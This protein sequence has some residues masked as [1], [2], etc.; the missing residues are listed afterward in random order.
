[1]KLKL[2]IVCL[3]VC[4]ASG[5][6]VWVRREAIQALTT[7]LV[8]D[9]LG[10][11]VRRSVVRGA[12][13]ADSL[14][15]QWEALSQTFRPNYNKNFPPQ[16]PQRTLSVDFA[17]RVRNCADEAAAKAAGVDVAQVR[18]AI[19][20]VEKSYRGILPEGFAYETYA[21]FRVYNALLP[22]S[23]GAA[24]FERRYGECLYSL[25]DPPPAELQIAVRVLCEQII[26]VGLADGLIFA[27]NVQDDENQDIKQIS[28][29]L[30]RPAELSARLLLEKQSGR[31]GFRI[32]PDLA[33][34]LLR[35]YLCRLKFID[36]SL[37]EYF[38]NPQY[39]VKFNP[40]DY[41]ALQIEIAI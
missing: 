36:F 27:T 3:R 8:S 25:F 9:D 12:Q 29:T 20:G 21:A 6:A 15:A 23:D 41:T 13:L 26:Q 38:L 16:F 2:F 11:T 14:D 32:L 40:D 33:T 24:D 39:R 22:S 5:L 19:L 31:L 10:T 30:Y 35:A 37:E 7:L 1:M 18:D 28:A 4:F 34:T 17:Q